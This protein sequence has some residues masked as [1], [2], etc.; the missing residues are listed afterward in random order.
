MQEESDEEL[1]AIAQCLGRS[2]YFMESR[3]ISSL[4]KEGFF[5]EASPSFLDPRTGKAREIDMIAERFDWDGDTHHRRVS[6]QTN[7]V[8]EAIN[9][10]F[11]FVLMTPTPFYPSSNH[12]DQIKYVLTP[13]S[14][15]PFLDELNEFLFTERSPATYE[16]YSQFAEIT[17]KKGSSELM[18][19]HGDGTYQS[20][21]KMSE[22][23]EERLH[24]FDGEQ[25][26]IWR[27]HFWR[28]VLVLGGSLVL[29]DTVGDGENLRYADYAQLAFN[30]HDQDRPRSTV[31]DVVTEAHLLTHMSAI[32]DRDTEVAIALGRFRTANFPE[33]LQS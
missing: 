17:R 8:V 26:E 2:G 28:P 3:I 18:A 16:L 10:R 32:C 19:S 24:G 20:L 25:R 4:C 14:N 31:I 5:V 27:L 22:Y 29:Q 15:N 1:A 21:L 33:V 9:N 23:I 13:E 12:E 11:P 30:W 7:F 6:V